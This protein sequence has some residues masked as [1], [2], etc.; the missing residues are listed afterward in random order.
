MRDGLVVHEAAS[1]A[2]SALRRVSRSQDGFADIYKVKVED[3]CKSILTAYNA[4]RSQLDFILSYNVYVQSVP[5]EYENKLQQLNQMGW[6]CQQLVRPEVKD[7]VVSE[8]PNV[9]M[10]RKKRIKR[11]VDRHVCNK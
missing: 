6:L 2:L 9:W 10:N 4:L 1:Y 3:P 7:T 11:T 5:P 8:A